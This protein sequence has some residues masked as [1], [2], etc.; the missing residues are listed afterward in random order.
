MRNSGSTSERYADPLAIPPT[1]TTSMSRSD[2][3]TPLASPL[4]LPTAVSTSEGLPT[5]NCSMQGGWLPLGTAEFAGEFRATSR[6]PR[7][8]GTSSANAASCDTSRTAGAVRSAIRCSSSGWMLHEATS[9]KRIHGH[10]IARM[11]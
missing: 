9:I 5:V 3:R 10:V 8:V 7:R 6:P 1:S 11:I 2:G 4:N